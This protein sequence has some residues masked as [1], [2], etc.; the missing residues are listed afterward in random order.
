MWGLKT[1]SCPNLPQC[2]W[3]HH[4]NSVSTWSSVFLHCQSVESW[5]EK[6]SKKY[7]S[8]P[9]WPLGTLTSADLTALARNMHREWVQG[10]IERR[11]GHPSAFHSS[12]L[13]KGKGGK[14][15][16]SVLW[17]LL[18]RRKFT[19]HPR[20]LTGEA[21]RVTPRLFEDRKSSIF[22]HQNELVPPQL[23]SWYTSLA[24]SHLPVWAK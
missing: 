13:R 1:K 9:L 19:C 6:S 14:C 21:I 11:T 17:K 12:T 23:L 24:S 20:N 15:L 16:N 7:I 5:G 22:S 8:K 2:K 3:L 4:I 18:L 10:A